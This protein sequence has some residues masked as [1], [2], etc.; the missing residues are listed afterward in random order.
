MRYHAHQVALLSST[1]PSFRGDSAFRTICCGASNGRVACL[2]LLQIW[3]WAEGVRDPALQQTSS[4]LETK[5]F[6]KEG[7][8]LRER[9]GTEAES[10]LDDARFAA[11][12]LREVEDRRAWPLRSARI[13]SIP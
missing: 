12:I 6:T 10:A 13:T 2:A 11:D 7:D 4:R 3:V 5:P 8:G 1:Q 9:A